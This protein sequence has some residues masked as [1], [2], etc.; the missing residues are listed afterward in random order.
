MRHVPERIRGEEN[1]WGIQGGKASGELEKAI[2][3]Y[4]KAPYRTIPSG[5]P[6]EGL[7]SLILRRVFNFSNFNIIF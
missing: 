6:I 1:C 2:G 5:P 7:K 4:P 3:G